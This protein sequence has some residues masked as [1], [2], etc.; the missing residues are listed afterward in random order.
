MSMFPEKQYGAA[1]S[2]ALFENVT[3]AVEYLEG[4]YDTLYN[5]GEKR[6]AAT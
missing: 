6:K 3:V 2:Y 5:M 1:A 4:E